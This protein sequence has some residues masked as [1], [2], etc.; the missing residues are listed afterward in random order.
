MTCMLCY[1]NIEG[2]STSIRASCVHQHKF[3]P[4]CAKLKYSL[5]TAEKAAKVI[6]VKCPVC[7]ENKLS[8][9]IGSL[10]TRVSKLKSGTSAGCSKEVADKISKA[11]SV[12]V[13]CNFEQRAL[14]LESQALE[15]ELSISGLLETANEDLNGIVGH[16]FGALEVPFTTTKVRFARRIGKPSAQRIGSAN[17]RQRDIL[18]KFNSKATVDSLIT[19]AKGKVIAGDFVGNNAF[20]GPVRLHRRHPQALYKLRQLIL[21]SYPRLPAQNVW[22]MGYAVCVR[23]S[24]ES[25][26]LRLL[27]S[28]GMEVTKNKL[29][30]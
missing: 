22:I 26:P 7:L 21:K 6:K 16:L 1:T 4:G 8:I 23:L 18:V 24:P 27:L 13:D 5:L 3:H 9:K 12:L 20:L 14:Q 29:S 19:N 28:S 10:K 11:A 25:S 30:Q 15:N 17:L 2:Y